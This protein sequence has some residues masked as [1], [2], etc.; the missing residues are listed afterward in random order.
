MTLPSGRRFG[1]SSTPSVAAPVAPAAVA[2][3]AEDLTA[4]HQRLQERAQTL[5]RNRLQG[6]AMLKQAEK[7]DQEM[8]QQVQALGVTTVEELEAYTTAREDADRAALLECEKML[9][10]EEALQ[11]QVEQALHALDN[12]A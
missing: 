6:E 4:L 2:P 5:F 9:D 3:S 12:G 8:A 7:Q 11:K 1:S 10:A